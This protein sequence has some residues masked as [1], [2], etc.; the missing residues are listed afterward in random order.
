MSRIAE[1]V[2]QQVITR[3]HGLCEYCQ[4]AQ[5]II[6]SIEID[7]IIPEAKG[8][9]DE[10]ENLCLACRGCN[11][12][13]QDFQHGIDPET[14]QE[15]SLFNPRTQSWNEN[16]KWDEESIRVVGLT[17]TGRATVDRLRM[18]RSEVVAARRLWVRAGWHP[19]VSGRFPLD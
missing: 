7:H 11:S 2:R 1:S 5:L 17:P 15:T 8:G 9:S 6:V 4:S 12:F 13:K 18:N 16:F 19:P 14:Q 10:L 3:A